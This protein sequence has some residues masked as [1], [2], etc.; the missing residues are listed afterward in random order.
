MKTT[1]GHAIRS[2]AAI[3]ANFFAGSEI[4]RGGRGARAANALR[5]KAVFAL[6]AHAA[7]EGKGFQGKPDV[8]VVAAV[9]AVVGA[10]G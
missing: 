7:A 3:C 9:V 6:D 5:R 8:V 10:F 2:A 1:I 4:I